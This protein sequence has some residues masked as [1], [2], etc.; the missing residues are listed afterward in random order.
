LTTEKLLCLCCRWP[1]QFK[2][3]DELAQQAEQQLEG[4]AEPKAAHTQQ[5]RH[6]EE[7]KAAGNRDAALHN[8]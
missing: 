1:W 6:H 3:I 8:L 2:R 4:T 7:K 5:Q